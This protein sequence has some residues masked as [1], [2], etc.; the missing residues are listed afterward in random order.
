MSLKAKQLSNRIMSFIRENK[1]WIDH[2]HPHYHNAG[3]RVCG[4]VQQMIEEEYERSRKS[5]PPA[6]TDIVFL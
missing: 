5:A 2:P 3:E 4:Q 1:R 6:I